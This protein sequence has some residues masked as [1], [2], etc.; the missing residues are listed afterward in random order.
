MRTRARR[1]AAV[2]SGAP[3][4]GAT[5]GA[6]QWSAGA[7]TEVAVDTAPGAAPAAEHG[8]LGV[9]ALPGGAFSL[10]LDGDGM[11]APEAY[12]RLRDS[13]ADAAHAHGRS[14]WRRRIAVG[15]GAAA[16]RL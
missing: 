8:R 11:D 12:C 4:A 7:T 15:G 3:P 2:R 6:S 14:T 16:C 13:C 1:F 10:T 5:N 9:T